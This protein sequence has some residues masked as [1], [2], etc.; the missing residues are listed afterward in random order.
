MQPKDTGVPRG[1]K[2]EL[3]CKAQGHPA[4]HYQ[5]RRNGLDL[6]GEVH[7]ELIISNYA[8]SSDSQPN[9]EAVFNCRV[10]NDAGY[11][12]T[13]RVTVK[14][15]SSGMGCGRTAYLVYVD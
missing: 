9:L 1:S 10:E 8:M 11:L 5:W 2:L 13:D 3:V 6:E 14:C 7:P 12:F 15:L 4:P